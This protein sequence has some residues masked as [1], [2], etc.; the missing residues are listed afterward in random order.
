M[1]FPGT[2]KARRSSCLVMENIASRPKTYL[3]RELIIIG[4]PWKKSFGIRNI[5]YFVF[6]GIFPC[7]EFTSYQRKMSSNP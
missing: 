5:K 3:I 2:D 7:H 6:Q 4:M 1:K